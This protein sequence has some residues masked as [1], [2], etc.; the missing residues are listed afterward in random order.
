[1]NSRVVALDKTVNQMKTRINEW[2][3][4]PKEKKLFKFPKVEKM[5][6]NTEYERLLKGDTQEFCSALKGLVR[7]LSDRR[8]LKMESVVAK[9][10]E[11]LNKD[12]K[13]SIQQQPPSLSELKMKPRLRTVI[14][15][16]AVD[17][18]SEPT[19][20]EP[21][22]RSIVL[23]RIDHIEQTSLRHSAP[24]PSVHSKSRAQNETSIQRTSAPPTS[25]LAAVSLRTLL[26]EMLENQNIM[27]TRDLKH[28][29]SILKHFGKDED[30]LKRLA[31]IERGM[32]TTQKSIQF[33]VTVLGPYSASFV[34]V[35]AV[36]GLICEVIRMKN[37]EHSNNQKCL[38]LIDRIDVMGKT[39]QK[40][41]GHLLKKLGAIL[42]D[43][44]PPS[45][46]KI[47]MFMED[48]NALSP[49]LKTIKSKV[50]CAK[51]HIEEW[52]SLPIKKK[53][54]VKPLMFERMTKSTEYE[55]YFEKD[56]DEIHKEFQSLN[57]TLLARIFLKLEYL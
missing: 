8:Y 28:I 15:A 53:V 40:L 21:R 4:S 48:I 25:Q 13:I 34:S 17:V 30:E 22:R 32:Q 45:E 23:E 31:R 33:V 57:T 18:P 50:D 39:I 46:E 3:C 49:H 35:V 7:V 47:Q 42:D 29:E 54:S 20:D 12:I 44:P 6:T 52:I 11:D 5:E 24:Q 10:P 19:K 2:T 26:N 51:K 43:V 56:D 38:D 41:Q 14:Q 37:R 9:L 55:E 16:T 1:V 27:E 36:S